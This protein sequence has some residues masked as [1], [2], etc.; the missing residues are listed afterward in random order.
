[1]LLPSGGRD[2]RIFRACLSALWVK[3]LKEK[4]WEG[5]ILRSAYLTWDPEA[6]DL[7][8]LQKQ[9]DEFL[10]SL[11]K[12]SQ[13]KAPQ[14]ASS[15]LQLKGF[16]FAHEGY[17]IYD[18]YLSQKAA[19]SIGRL[20]GVGANSLAIVPYTGTG[21]IQKPSELGISNFAG[22]ENDESVIMSA[23]FARQKGMTTLLKPQIWVRGGWPGDLKMQSQEDWDQF[24]AFY[25]KWILH[26]ALLA[27]LYEMESFCVGV[28]LKYTTL[29]QGKKW[30]A[31]IQDIRKIYSGPL[32]YAANWGEEF[33]G[34]TFW[35]ELD[36]IGVDF[37]YPIGKESKISPQEL[38]KNL[39]KE[40]KKV[41]GVSKAFNKPV[42]LT[43]IGFRSIEA[44]WQMPHE[45]AGNK[46]SNPNDQALCY[47]TV[48]KSLQ[49]KE[50]CKGIYWW[51]WPSYIAFTQV[52][53]RGYSPIG[54]PAEKVLEKWFK[55]STVNNP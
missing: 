53:D 38:Q 44:P 32:V 33:E 20:K 40:L 47:E 55:G 31:L 1:M 50:W 45:H 36:Y 8:S 11:P 34:I 18:G 52:Q 28:E 29:E 22:G 37:Y 49:D 15:T 24:F 48:L 42:I 19:N 6:E 10:E 9:W 12:L 13:S 27:E 21:S 39:E 14:L 46:A 35:D 43:E 41:E 16:N 54:K 25:K 26:Y 3:F 51:K 2:S 4:I 7:E 17:N 5:Q 23:H 30:R